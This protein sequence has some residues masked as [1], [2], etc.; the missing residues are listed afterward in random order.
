MVILIINDSV[1]MRRN[2]VLI[3]KFMC[4]KRIPVPFALIHIA[5][6]LDSYWHQLKYYCHV[7][8]YT[9]ITGQLGLIFLLGYY[10]IRVQLLPN[11]LMMNTAAG[12]KILWRKI[13]C[14]TQIF[15]S[16]KEYE[17]NNLYFLNLQNSDNV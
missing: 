16:Y 11:L 2:F 15:L 3:A 10:S 7:T 8:P 5:N 1:Y 12:Y 4:W 17:N 14:M 9:S 6:P 13:N